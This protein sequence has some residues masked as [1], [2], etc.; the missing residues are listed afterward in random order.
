MEN[1][2]KE[3]EKRIKSM[4]TEKGRKEGRKKRPGKRMK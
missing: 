1:K 4:K 3:K 2:E